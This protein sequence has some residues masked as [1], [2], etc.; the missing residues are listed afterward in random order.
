MTDREIIV[1]FVGVK[2]L[3]GADKKTRKS[4]C[5][6]HYF[7]LP[8]GLRENLFELDGYP[9]T[10]RRALTVLGIPEPQNQPAPTTV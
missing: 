4:F 3:C 8:Q 6:L 1:N 7:A 2:C 10:F 9:E 5:R